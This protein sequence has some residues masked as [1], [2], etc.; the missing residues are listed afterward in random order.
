[1][2]QSLILGVLLLVACSHQAKRV[3]CDQHLIPINPPAPVS[4]DVALKP[5]TTP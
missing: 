1:M 2:R 4:K 5:K 3:E